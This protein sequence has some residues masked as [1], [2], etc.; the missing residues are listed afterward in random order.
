LDDTEK[1][2]RKAVGCRLPLLHDTLDPTPAEF[3]F[4]Y[5]SLDWRVEVVMADG[6]KLAVEL[7]G[8]L[9]HGLSYLLFRL[10]NPIF[11]F[12]HAQRSVVRLAENR[13]KIGGLDCDLRCN[14]RAFH[15]VDVIGVI[16]A[17]D[18]MFVAFG[19]QGRG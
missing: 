4:R 15:S 6:F 8:L 17:I 11:H 13:W 18:L 7:V 2:E 1:D 12:C 5:L 16:D 3:A 14:V 19:W 9:L 10:F